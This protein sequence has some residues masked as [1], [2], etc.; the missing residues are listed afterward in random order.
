MVMN[1]F[2]VCI[3]LEQCMHRYTPLYACVDEPYICNRY[4]CRLC[5]IGMF[6][7]VQKEI[8]NF[9]HSFG[10]TDMS[11]HHHTYFSDFLFL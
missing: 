1:K 10:H 11:I 9:M 3:G 2:P 6:I 8:C 4:V 7:L 5:T